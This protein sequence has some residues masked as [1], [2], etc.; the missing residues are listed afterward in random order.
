MSDPRSV[1]LSRLGLLL[2]AS[3]EQAGV[4]LSDLA[5]RLHLGHEQLQALEQGE[6]S[7]LPEPVFVVAMARRIA[8]VLGIGIDEPLDAYKRALLDPL[9]A[10]PAA[11]AS[12]DPGRR[13]WLRR[14]R[15]RFSTP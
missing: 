9:P 8:E 7:R 5:D 2:S 10:Q 6:P 14:L 12:P 11:P 1:A 4:E 3:R 13:S 15:L